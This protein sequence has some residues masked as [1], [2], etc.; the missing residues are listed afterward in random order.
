MRWGFGS[1]SSAS[2]GGGGDE[3]GVRG[4]SLRNPYQGGGVFFLRLD[5][6]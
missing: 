1:F 5:V 4:L 2:L 3:W 6:R